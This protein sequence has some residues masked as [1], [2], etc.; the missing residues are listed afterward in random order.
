MLYFNHAGTSWPKPAVVSEAVCDAMHVPPNEWGDRF[1]QA[2][3]A[4]AVFLG[5]S[6]PEQILLTPGCTSS[7]SVAIQGV[8][9][10]RGKRVLTSHWEHHALHRPILQ[11]AS[12]GLQV[13]YIPSCSHERSAASSL[14]DL[15]WLERECL[16]G[17]VGLVALTAACNVTGDLL[18]Y[19]EVVEIAHRHG[20][21]VLID[22]AQVVGWQRLDLTRLDADL[23]AFGG[24]KGLQSPW[25][26]GGLYFSERAKME[27]TSAKCDLPISSELQ[28]RKPPRPGYCDV[29]SVDQFALAGFHAALEW[30]RQRDDQSDLAKSR[31]QIQRMRRS[32]EDDD[33]VS[34]LGSSN[35]ELR[36]P[37]LAF[38]I[39][40]M[41]SSTAASRCREQGL[42]VGSGLHCA[43][44][45]HESLGTESV[46][47]LRL[48][49]GIGQ[50]DDDVDVA[51][52]ILKSVMD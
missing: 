22:A 9:I 48:S 43:P 24:H 12:A 40:G 49:V 20:A 23:V 25:G 1:E 3:Q 15:D 51:I 34:L 28:E 30:L 26:I 37:T 19:E 33:R 16:V 29:G 31:E 18:P 10:E 36:M 5:V 46:G 52:E 6:D 27:C 2:H 21:P 14:I 7:L 8:W 50:H 35:P 39:Q 41:S 17:D 44:L 45:A 13:D 42:I 4:I 38:S 32:L 47:A 11:L